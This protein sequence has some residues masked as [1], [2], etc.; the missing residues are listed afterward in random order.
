MRLHWRMIDMEAL[1]VIW[2]VIM[3]IAAI[4]G[5]VAIRLTHRIEALEEQLKPI[6]NPYAG[7]SSLPPDQPDDHLSRPSDNGYPTW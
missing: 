7:G 2:I 6:N 1:L 5:I 4:S 3:A